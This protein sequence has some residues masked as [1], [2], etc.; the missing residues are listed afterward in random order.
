[1]I[2]DIY[3]TNSVI[4]FYFIVKQSLWTFYIKSNKKECHIWTQSKII[5]GFAT[6]YPI[7]FGHLKCGT[8]WGYPKYCY[9]KIGW[10]DY[11][12]TLKRNGDLRLPNY[13]DIGGK[14]YCAVWGYLQGG[15]H[16]FPYFKVNDQGTTCVFNVK[17]WQ[18]D[19]ESW[20]NCVKLFEVTVTLLLQMK[21][22][23]KTNI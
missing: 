21:S 19:L 18:L 14:W 4:R 8:Y 20:N 12:I 15:Y 6:F 2:L 9:S 7:L 17:F 5:G 16:D 1:M 23:Y 13:L 11:T 3:G 10:K 22:L